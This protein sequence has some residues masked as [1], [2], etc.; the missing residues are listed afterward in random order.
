LYDTHINL[1]T[2]SMVQY[3]LWKVDSYSA[4]QRIICFLYG[5]RRF[6]TVLTKVRHQ[7]LF[8]VC[9]I[10]FAPSI[11]ISLRSIL[12]LSSHQRLRLPGGLFP[13]GVSAKILWTLLPSPMR[14]TCP[15]HPIL[16]D[17]I[18]LTILG[19]EYQLWSSS[20]C[21]F[22]HDPSSSL[23]G[24][25]I[26]LRTLFSKSPQSVFLPQSERPSLAPIQ[27]KWQNYS[28]VYF[29]ILLA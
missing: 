8:R 9:R 7:T 4:C 6:I 20:L 1:L 11:P 13:S 5:T 24:P 27:H 18:T 15:A 21:S 22:L 29:K 25:Y 14:A 26:F 17:L 12:M 28:F 2:Y 23:L 16:L 10:Q 19:K 3:I